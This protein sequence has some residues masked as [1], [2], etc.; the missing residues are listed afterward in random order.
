MT[1][2]SEESRNFDP[3]KSKLK[4][5]LAIVCAVFFAIS[6]MYLY[7][8]I[9]YPSDMARSIRGNETHFG[10]SSEKDTYIG[11]RLLFGLVGLVIGLFSGRVFGEFIYRKS[12]LK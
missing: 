10:W 1:I 9:L 12:G 8:Q 5:V 2:T 4:F 3:L 11:Y 7:D 6:M